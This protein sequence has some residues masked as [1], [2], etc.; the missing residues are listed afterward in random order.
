MKTDESLLPWSSFAMETGITRQG[1]ALTQS[2]SRSDDIY[3]E[4][5]LRKSSQRLVIWRSFAK[6]SAAVSFVGGLLQP[7]LVA[8]SFLKYF[9]QF[10]FE[11]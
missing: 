6:I 4:I 8:F 10:S 2:Y 1:A 7:L 5:I 11:I 3:M 9:S